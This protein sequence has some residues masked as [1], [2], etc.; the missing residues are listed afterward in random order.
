[1]HHCDR[2]TIAIARGSNRSR[3]P[4]LGDSVSDFLRVPPASHFDLGATVVQLAP[5]SKCL[6]RNNKSPDAIKATKKCRRG[7]GTTAMTKE[8]TK[9][10]DEQ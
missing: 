2:N 3:G 1:V 7:H 6:A 9:S 5:E 8:V 4:R 10:T